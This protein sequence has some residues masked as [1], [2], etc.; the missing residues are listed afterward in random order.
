MKP[1]IGMLATALVSAVAAIGA[2]A[3][4]PAAPKIGAIRAQL[5]YEETGKLSNDILSDKDL[6]LWNTIIGEGGAGGASNYTLVTVEVQGKDVPVGAVKVQVT[7]RNSKRKIIAMNTA[8]VSIYD[9]KTR[10]NAPLFLYNTGCDEIE[11]SASLLGKGISRNEVKAKIPF[12][13]GE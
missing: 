12:A 4:G 8:D 10:F 13:C 11:I 3:A 1:A 6:S 7:A 2:Q 9:A 5:Y